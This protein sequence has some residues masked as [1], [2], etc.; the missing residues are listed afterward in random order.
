MADVE[1]GYDFKNPTN[2]F[3][4]KP[5]NQNDVEINTKVI[6]TKNDEEI[7]SSFSSKEAVEVISEEDQKLIDDEEISVV[8]EQVDLNDKLLTFNPESKRLLNNKIDAAKKAARNRFVYLSDPSRFERNDYNLD[9]QIKVFKKNWSTRYGINTLEERD[10]FLKKEKEKL[11]ENFSSKNYLPFTREELIKQETDVE[12]TD[13]DKKIATI[14]SYL[15]SPNYITS[16][17]T[18]Q[19]LKTDL[20]IGQLNSLVLG[21]MLINPV[22]ALV[23]SPYHFGLFQE[24]LKEGKYAHAA[25]YLTLTLFDIAQAN[26]IAKV[27]GKGMGAVRAKIIGPSKGGKAT[28]TVARLEK[29]SVDAIRRSNADEAMKNS[30]LKDSLISEFEDKTKITVSKLNE[31]GYKVLDSKISRTGSR[32]KIDEISKKF[33]GKVDETDA[34]KNLALDN[35]NVNLANSDLLLPILNPEKLDG[36]VA[37]V[38]KLRKQTMINADGKEVL[39]FP[40]LSKKGGDRKPLV[41]ELLD[42]TVNKDLLGDVKIYDML[43]EHN[44]SFEDYILTIL[45]SASDAGK[46]LNKLSQI[47]RGRMRNLEEIEDI[48]RLKLDKTENSIKKFWKYTFVRGEG[49]AR[50]AMVSSL[51]TAMRNAISGMVRMPLESLS[52]V[53]DA[54]LYTYATKGLKSAVGTTIPFTKGSSWAG[55]FKGMRLLASPEYAKEYTDFFLKRPEFAENMS[56]MFDNV[57][58][59]RKFRGR[60]KLEGPLTKP[61]D[62]TMSGLEDLVQILNGP[63]KLQEFVI[64]RATFLGELERRL[65]LEWDIDL[66]DGLNSGKFTMQDLMGDVS[67]LRKPGA[68]D[69]KSIM[70]DSVRKALDVTYAKTPDWRPFRVTSNFITESGLTAIIPFPRFMFNAMEFVAEHSAGALLPA[71]RRATGNAKGPLTKSERRMVSRN[72]MGLTALTG[73]MMYRNSEDAPADYKMI[74]KDEFVD[75]TDED[76]TLIDTT[77]LFPVRQALWIVEA[78]ERSNRFSGL[79]TGSRDVVAGTI[80]MWSGFSKKE[81]LDVFGGGGI[82]TGVANVWVKGITDI[83]DG[84]GD[85]LS[86]AKWAKVFGEAVGQWQN[87]IFT[88]AFQLVEGQRATVLDRYGPNERLMRPLEYKEFRGPI[89]DDLSGNWWDQAFE[90]KASIAKRRGLTTAPTTETELTNTQNIFVEPSDGGRIEVREKL[91]YG[92]NQRRLDKEDKE[93]LIELGYQNVDYELASRKQD[94]NARAAENRELRK[95]I[96]IAIDEAMKARKKLKK[97]KL[98]KGEKEGTPFNRDLVI[99]S[100]EVFTG[101]VRSYMQSS[102]IQKTIAGSISPLSAAVTRYSRLS[103]EKR[104]IA[105][106]RFKEENP[107]EEIDF[108][109]LEHIKQLIKFANIYK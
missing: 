100:R 49:I 52:N 99:R 48:N 55:S 40:N 54:A 84:M 71:L 29:E 78:I 92:W 72:M 47:K 66:I 65:K 81:V 88:P 53:M 73:L 94:R 95:I 27:T 80:D 79:M 19:L 36:L 76:K 28:G 6:E 90:A 10:Y 77:T 89:E 51:A 25:G 12:A 58:E 87:R 2:V 32:K 98:K 104:N 37:L 69:F 102:G 103:R 44:L 45:G 16:G 101:F 61:Y 106:L 60:G 20:T 91:F 8:T 70:D 17:L 18:E 74:R 109:N 107:S 82:R 96:P 85:E 59:V 5:I 26:V 39:R 108:L 31:D 57:N 86:D 64:R 21:D 24:R 13:V 35:L 97:E 43:A 50:G 9:E 93:F 15:K 38:S 33:G 22:T 3:L 30:E 105:K 11:G 42:M 56:K 4:N 83:I 62:K 1:L 46:L 41:D 68:D 34:Q 63:N 67:T 23:D 75:L 14:E 7:G